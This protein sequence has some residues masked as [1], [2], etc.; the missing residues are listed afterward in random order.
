MRVLI[1]RVRESSVTVKGET[2]GAIGPG[3]CVL[4]GVGPDDGEA[5]VALLA[6]KTA[7]LRIFEDADGKTNLSVADV[8]GAV[9]VVSQFT[10]YADTRKGRRPSFIRAAAPAQA[11]PL[12]A[13][14][15]ELLRGYGLTVAGGRFGAHMVVNIVNDGPFTVWLDTAEQ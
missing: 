15:A 8:G 9:L 12:V 13:R 4:V 1:Q 2:V 5:E 7:E 6:R 11:E 14:F 3:L 10:L